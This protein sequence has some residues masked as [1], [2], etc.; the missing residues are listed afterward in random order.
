[1]SQRY[2]GGIITANPTAPTLSSASG[3]W[4]TEQQFQNIANWPK[5]TGL[6]SRSV[7]LRSSASAGFYRTLTSGNRQIYTWSGWVKRGIVNSSTG[8]NLV[9]VTDNVT[10]SSALYFNTFASGVTDCLSFQD[11]ATSTQLTTTQVFRDPSAWYH[12][13]LAV[14]TTQAISSNRVKL[15]VNGLQITSFSTATYPSQNANT[16]FNLSGYRN[17]I[18]MYWTSNYIS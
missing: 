10:T 6:V 15:Y 11:Q 8:Q 12:I 2:L 4:T 9:S 13:V 14:D 18:G 7:R 5:S 17:S 16:T 3:V 1:M